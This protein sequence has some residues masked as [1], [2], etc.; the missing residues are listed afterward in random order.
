VIKNC[1]VEVPSLLLWSC[2]TATSSSVVIP[3][4]LSM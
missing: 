1:F 2:N 3:V 4:T